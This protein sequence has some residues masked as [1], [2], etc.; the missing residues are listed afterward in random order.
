MNN[1]LLP[2]AVQQN[3]LSKSG[4]RAIRSISGPRPLAF[5]RAVVINWLTIISGVSIA[6]LAN[7]TILSIFAVLLVATR[8]LVFVTLIHEQAHHLAFNS[9]YGDLITNCLVAYP[10]LLM[11]VEDYSEVHLSHHRHFFTDKDPDHL[12]KNGDNWAMPIPRKRLLKLLL[13][14][15]CG[16]SVWRFY[17]GKR[18][19]GKQRGK[20]QYKRRMCLPSWVK[21]LYLL[22]AVLLI[23]WAQAWSIVLLYWLLPLATFFHVMIRWGALCEHIYNLPGASVEDC[24]PM[25]ILSWWERLLLPNM[26]FNYHIYHHYYPGVSYSQLP[27]VHKIYGQ[28][29]LVN[30]THVFYGY[31]SILKFFLTGKHENSDILTNHSISNI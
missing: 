23:T 9:R 20:P 31:K 2:A 29:G 21:P 15:I 28:E 13:T 11:T 24:T 7:S 8:Q 4:K 25:I 17:Q 30:N 16:L 6:V 27:A 5:M 18:M 19:A 10:L 3:L 22:V 12:R 26:N 14:D 1:P